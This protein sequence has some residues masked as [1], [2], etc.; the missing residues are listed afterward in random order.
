VPLLDNS[1]RPDIPR[2]LEAL[3]LKAVARDKKLRFE[4]AEEF[5][6]A[7]ERGETR[8]T[9][10]TAAHAPRGP[11]SAVAMAFAC[12]GVRHIEPAAANGTVSRDPA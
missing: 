4:T 12:S 2:W 1:Y 6:L 8:P 10:P 11:G 7:L 5:L 9:Y 3:L